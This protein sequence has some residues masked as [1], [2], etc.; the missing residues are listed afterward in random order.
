[1]SGDTQIV[2]LNSLRS[3]QQ[4]DKIQKSKIKMQN[5][6]THYMRVLENIP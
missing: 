6:G 5:C 3:L 4:A 2:L 1:M